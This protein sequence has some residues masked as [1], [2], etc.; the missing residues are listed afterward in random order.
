MHDLHNENYSAP[1]L[2]CSHMHL[3][4]D[5]SLLTMLVLCAVNICPEDGKVNR[6]CFDK[7]QA[8]VYSFLE[9]RYLHMSLI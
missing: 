5:L 3:Y 6:N 7:A 2:C 1:T 4:F 8:F 9:E